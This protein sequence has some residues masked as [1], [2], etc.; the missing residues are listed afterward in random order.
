MTSNEQA[1]ER[2]G[3]GITLNSFTYEFEYESSTLLSRL[4]KADLVTLEFSKKHKINVV[5]P[6]KEYQNWAE[7]DD[8]T[9]V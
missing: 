9:D 6:T 1:L 7:E 5:I 4:L 2:I 3:K 8:R